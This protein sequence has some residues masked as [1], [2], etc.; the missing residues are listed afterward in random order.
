MQ[1]KPS[2][3]DSYSQRRRIVLIA[4]VFLPLSNAGHRLMGEIL[5]LEETSV[6]TYIASS[7]LDYLLGLLS[8]DVGIDLG[9][10][11]TLVHVRGKGIVI[12]EPSVVAMHKKSKRVLAIGEEAKKMLGRNPA[13]I[14]VI[15]PLKDGVIADFDATEVMLKHYILQ[16]HES[17]KIIPRIPRPRVVIGIPSGVTEV[18]RRAVQEA[19][20]S[21]GAR[22]C[23]LI[24]EPMAAAI[25]AGLP[26]TDPG[27]LLI[28]D[29]GGGNSEIAV[30]SLGGIV[31]NKS[32]RVAGDEM[33]EAIMH[34][35]RLKYNVLLGERTAEEIKITLGN[36]HAGTTEKVM[37]IRG[38]DLESGLPRSIKIS[39]SEVREALM[40]VLRE[41]TSAVGDLIEETPPELVSDILERGI[42]MCG[43]GALISGMDKL[44]SEETRMPVYIT[45]DPLTAVVR[46]CG[47]VLED[48]KLLNKVRV[49]GG[50][51]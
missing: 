19:A 16:V 51:R 20:L 37:V 31:L 41:I 49:V 29:I 11:N 10:A 26:I 35:M 44:M 40:P 13:T 28:V 32:L 48:M 14:E 17:G 38:R 9:T 4:P 34:Y 8:Y 5:V 39:A 15:R 47:K 21:A 46:G 50:L 1:D 25:G 36:A 12:R 6:K 43:G 45:D 33:D 18:E 27:G 24:E 23:W 30:I 2:Q 22:Q 7:M 42:V 3:N